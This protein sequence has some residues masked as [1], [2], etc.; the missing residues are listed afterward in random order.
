MRCG[1]IDLGGTK[2][3]ARLFDG[4]E[5]KTLEKRRIAT[6]KTS[7]ADMLEAVV[8][9]INW[10]RSFDA[11]LPVGIAVPGV[12]DPETGESFASNIPSSGHAIGRDLEQRVGTPIAVIN[13][14]MAFALSEAT[15]GAAE[16]AQVT[17]GLIL[18]TG[19]G[20]G[21]CI[22]GKI[23]PRHA[24]LAVEVGHLGISNRALAR[25]DLPLWPCGCGRMGCIE[26]YISGTGLTNLAEW[27][28]GRRLSGE[29]IVKCDTPD[30]QKV[31]EIWADLAGDCLH[32]IQLVL[33]PDCI[34]LG[35]GLSNITG[36]TEILTE[37]LTRQR[38]GN[39]RLPNI[40]TARHGDSSGARGAAL[41]ATKDNS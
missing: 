34:V 28:L 18:G 41:V 26:N 25:H 16:G 22:D 5:T 14:C 30:T 9:Q 29:D 32:A 19:V 4:P 3:E 23:P 8:E 7:Y 33:D 17:M 39:A 35:G 10:L 36:I 6:P 31:M 27:H 24:G 15:G 37:S 21:L 1:G 12:I 40:V 13:D 20:G 38:L 2:I 11:N